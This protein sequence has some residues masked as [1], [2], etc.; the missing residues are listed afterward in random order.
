R[1]K[2]GF[3]TLV[4]DG[5]RIRDV[6]SDR[7]Q[8]VRLR[9]H[10]RNTG[11]HHTVE[12]HWQLLISCSNQLKVRNYRAGI[13]KTER[14]NRHTDPIIRGKANGP[15]LRETVASGFSTLLLRGQARF[16]KSA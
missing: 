16:R 3:R 13:R 6:V 9:V 15:R 10:S 8:A 2:L 7:R 1:R 14:L 4:T 12:A 11:P 5:A